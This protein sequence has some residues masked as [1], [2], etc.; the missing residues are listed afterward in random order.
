MPHILKTYGTEL[1]NSYHLIPPCLIDFVGMEEFVKWSETFKNDPEGYNVSRFV[2]DFKVPKDTFEFILKYFGAEK[3]YFD[4]NA[5]AVYD[6]TADEYYS[7]KNRGERLRIHFL[8]NF[9]YCLKS[10]LIT[11]VTENKPDACQAW[12]ARQNDTREWLRDPVP[13]GISE[14]FLVFDGQPSRWDIAPFIAEFGIEKAEVEKLTALFSSNIDTGQSLKIDELFADVASGNF[15][16]DEDYILS[17]VP[18][19][20]AEIDPNSGEA[21]SAEVHGEAAAEAPA[22]EA[23]PLAP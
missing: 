6:G 2:S 16:A 10:N 19:M 18:D 14:E 13:E 15:K 7:D 5:D 20:P 11:Y 3:Y 22:A 12:C 8:N 1:D 21:P 9:I 17:V 4:R 23:A